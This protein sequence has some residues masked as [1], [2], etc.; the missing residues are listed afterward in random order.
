M[1]TGLQKVAIG[2][3]LFVAFLLTSCLPE[4]D[5]KSSLTGLTSFG[6]TADENIPGLENIE[7]NID[8]LNRTI[9]NSVPLPYNS[10][11]TSLIATF[12]A[13]EKTTVTVDGIVQESG[14]TANDFSRTLNYVVTAENGWTEITYEVKVKVSQVE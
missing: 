9:T 11:V 13:I 2:C 7:F 8:A 12:E 5:V 14:V 10:D 6:F 4:D 1:R 3:V